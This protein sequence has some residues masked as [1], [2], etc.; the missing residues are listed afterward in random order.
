VIS[1]LHE[2]VELAI[3]DFS[4]LNLECFR[5]GVDSV[6]MGSGHEGGDYAALSLQREKCNRPQDL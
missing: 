5:L 1:L 2:V 4:C 6:W 3:L